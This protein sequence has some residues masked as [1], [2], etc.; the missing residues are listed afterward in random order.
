MKN[1]TIIFLG[2]VIATLAGLTQMA[3]LFAQSKR[4]EGSD[5]QERDEIRRTIQLAPGAR[6]EVSNIRGPVEVETADINAAEVHVVRSAQ[7]RGDLGQY[8]VAIENGSQGLTISGVQTQRD[9]NSGYDPEVRHHVMLRLPR[10]V[11]LT[12]R[13]IGG[14]V[15]VGDITGQ[16]VVNVVG[17]SLNVGAVDGQVQISSVGGQVSLGRASRPVEIKTVTGALTI[18]GASD[19]LDITGVGGPVSI[20]VSKLGQG[21]VQ[22]QTVTGQVELRFKDEL[23]AQLS[24][25]TVVGELS[26][27]LPN[28]TIQ[29]RPGPSSVRAQIGRGGPPIKINSVSKNVRLVKGT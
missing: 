3:T 14:N 2:G 10:R 29:S 24:T 16:L 13:S 23:N 19:S 6:V 25:D 26:I 18:G 21:G 20:G 4:V 28:V 15:K 17:G 9:T 8:P 22:I 27:D 7:S 5:L 12:I 11:S 1:T